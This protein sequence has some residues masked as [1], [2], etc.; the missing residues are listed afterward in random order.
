L[1]YNI[2]IHVSLT[3]PHFAASSAK[4]LVF[5]GIHNIFNIL[6]SLGVFLD[7]GFNPRHQNAKSL[8]EPK[9]RL[10]IMFAD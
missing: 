5:N 8:V 2:A 10:G 4:R 7:L 6:D 1:C 3:Q 9:T